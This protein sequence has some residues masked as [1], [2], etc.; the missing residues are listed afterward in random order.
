MKKSITNRNLTLINFIIVGYF[1]LIYAVDF[2]KIDFVLVG[3]FRELFTIPF[4]IAQIVF[5]IIGVKYLTEHKSHLL[6]TVSIMLLAIC[7]TI[8]IGSFF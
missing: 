3:V 2:Y 5:L 4:L 7:T 1:I 6:T 8:T